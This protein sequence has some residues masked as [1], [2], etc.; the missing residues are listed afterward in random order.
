MGTQKVEDL[1]MR[2]FAHCRIERMDRDTTAGKGGHAKILGRFAAG[3]ID[4]L[5]GT[6]MIAKGHDYP[7]VTLV[8]VVNA[9]TGLSLPD[10][11]AAENT[12]QLVT[13]V[14]GRAGRGDRP[15]EVIIQT[16]RPKHYA[17]QAAAGHD[18]AGFYEQE[19]ANRKAAGYPPF[20]RMCNFAIESEDPVLA[21]RAVSALQRIV[22]D[23]INVLGFRGLEVVGPAPATISRVK[24]KY[25]WN[26]GALS[27]SAKRLNALTRATRDAFR[28]EIPNTRVQLKVDLDPYGTF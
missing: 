19:L 10:F 8:G 11:R 27:K 16:Y 28:S 23:Q 9:D 2:T 24:K 6:Q 25:R 13:Q 22:R 18:Y 4:I 26:L 1:L 7:S 5:I 20:R 15:G 21:Q 3:E 14:A 17:I 12:F